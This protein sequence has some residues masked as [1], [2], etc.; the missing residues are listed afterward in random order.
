MYP[1]LRFNSWGNLTALGVKYNAAFTEGD[2]AA[3]WR[4]KFM[5][6]SETE[7][8]SDKTA[9]MTHLQHGRRDDFWPP[10]VSL[11]CPF[12]IFA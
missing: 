8:Q 4:A 10:L 2:G 12:D 1:C 9:A 5:K 6:P 3:F 7:T 11:S